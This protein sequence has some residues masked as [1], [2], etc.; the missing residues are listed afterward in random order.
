M[1]RTWVEVV[2]GFCS[3]TQLS[4]SA[5]CRAQLEGRPQQSWK[6]PS[7]A[8]P[9]GPWAVLLVQGRGFIGAL[10]VLCSHDL[11]QSALQASMWNYAHCAVEERSRAAFPVRQQVNEEPERKSSLSGCEACTLAR[12]PATGRG[13]TMNMAK[14]VPL[15][16]I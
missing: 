11:I 14:N 6:T 7:Q 1:A 2:H 8:R 9:G 5:L 10:C 15:L 3:S 13:R 16:H 4:P 12:P